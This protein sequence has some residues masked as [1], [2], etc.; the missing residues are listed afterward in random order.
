MS[1]PL[2]GQV[3]VVTGGSRG[4]GAATAHALAQAGATVVLTHRDS[5]PAAEEVVAALPGGEHRAVQASVTDTESLNALATGVAKTEGRLRTYVA[6][7]PA[8]VPLVTC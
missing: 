4:I 1:A 6:H 7:L 5:G 8:C 2:T 3:A